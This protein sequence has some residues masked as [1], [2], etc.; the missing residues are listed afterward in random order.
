M[1]DNWTVSIDIVLPDFDNLHRFLESCFC[2][3]ALVEM[4]DMARK[5]RD[6]LGPVELEVLRK[7]AAWLFAEF[8]SIE[9]EEEHAET[10]TQILEAMQPNLRTVLSDPLAKKLLTE[11]HPSPTRE[12]FQPEAPNRRYDTKLLE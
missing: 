8:K 9:Q 10:M 12:D 1:V 3:P 4:L 11:R 5:Q 6:E 2:F 7:A